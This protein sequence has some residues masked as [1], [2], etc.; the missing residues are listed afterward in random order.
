MIAAYDA[1]EAEGVVDC[2]EG[3]RGGGYGFGDGVG[4]GDV[5]DDGEDPDRGEFGGEFGYGRLG[6]PDCRFEVPEGEACG[7]VFEKGARGGEGE[8][9]GAAGYWEVCC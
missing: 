1:G 6:G 4:R 9:A 3:L 8:G 2:A 5:D 7:A